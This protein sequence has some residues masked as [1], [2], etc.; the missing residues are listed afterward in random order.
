MVCYTNALRNKLI[1]AAAAALIGAGASFASSSDVR[2][3]GGPLVIAKQ[4]Y[5]FAGGTIDQSRK[6]TPT[7]GHMYVEFQIPQKL[8]HRYPLV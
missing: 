2:A 5:F 1:R 3:Q 8:T 6:G 7:V 4:G